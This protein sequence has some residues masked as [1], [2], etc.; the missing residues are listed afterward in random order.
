MA[1]STGTARSMYDDAKL[2]CLPTATYLRNAI[3]ELIGVDADLKRKLI[4]QRYAEPLGP[5]PSAKYVSGTIRSES[6]RLVRNGNVYPFIKVDK[7]PE[8]V[9][10]TSDGRTRVHYNVTFS[11]ILGDG[12]QFIP[13]SP[14][15]AD[16][17]QADGDLTE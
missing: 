15:E 3:I 14:A 11:P 4:D 16:L 17:R 6:G 8:K 7:Q 9:E 10:R 12:A 2:V 1:L 13:A 5:W